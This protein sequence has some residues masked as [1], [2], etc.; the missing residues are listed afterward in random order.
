MTQHEFIKRLNKAETAKD[1]YFL[2]KMINSNIYKCKCKNKFR[3]IAA[4]E[5]FEC[6]N[7]KLSYLKKI[8]L[9]TSCGDSFCYHVKDNDV[10]FK[11]YK[12]ICCYVNS[13]NGRTVELWVKT[14]KVGECI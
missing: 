14:F 11:K 6:I 5:G 4:N 9:C 3:Y 10:V 1:I 7:I 2:R 8:T 13:K 12:N